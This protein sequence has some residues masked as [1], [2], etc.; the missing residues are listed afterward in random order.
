MYSKEEAQQIRTKFWISF[1]QYM[2]LHLSSEGESI[3]WVNY[4][5]G[6]KD[7]FFKTDISNKSAKI[8]IEIT[9]KDLSIQELMYEQFQE[10]QSM[11]HSYFDEEWIWS[12]QY[13]DEQG[14]IISSIELTLEGVSIFRESDWVIIINFLKTNLINLDGFWNDVKDSFEMFK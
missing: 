8:S 3:N 12:K 1:G 6:I 14:K 2:K 5:T 10:F 7:L 9:H 11:F 4:K 13:S